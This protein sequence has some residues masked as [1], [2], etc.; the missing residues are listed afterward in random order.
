[1]KASLEAGKVVSCDHVSTI[2]DGTAVKTVGVN[3]L[4]YVMRFVDDI[5]TV[6]DDELIGAFLDMVENHKTVVENSG[7]LSVA[8]LK[9]LDIKG[10][11]VR[12]SVKISVEKK[13]KI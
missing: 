4:P 10:K 1:M 13:I 11:K 8:A 7:L 5:V 12:K 2:A 9:Q 3:N 6:N